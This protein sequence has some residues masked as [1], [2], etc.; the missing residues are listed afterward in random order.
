MRAGVATE[1]VTVVFTDLVGSTELMSRRGE[2]AADDLRREHFGLLRTAVAEHG[3][4]EVKNLGDGLMVVF[5]AVTG[6]LAC[7]VAMQQA[8]AGRALDT[9][10]LSIRVG[11][12]SGD[13]EFDNDDYFGLPVVEA[14]RLC[15][16]ADGGEILTTELVRMLARSRSD[17]ELVSVGALELKGLDEPV[18]TFRVRWSPI[19][20]TEE[21]PPLPS[22]L[23]SART[24]NFVGRDAE[25]I[26]LAVA[27]KTI[28]GG[29]RRMMFLAGEPGIGKTTL[30]AQFA[31]DVYDEGGL[32]VYGRSDED[33]GVPYQPWIEAFGQLVAHAPEQ[34]LVSHVGARGAH[35]ARLVPQ[36]AERLQ[37]EAP[38]GGDAD[39]E[40]FVLYGCVTDL[41]SRM[42]AEQPVLFVL[43][44]LHWA[45]R[46]TVQ[47][48][49][50][51]ANAEQ[52]MRVGVLGTFRDSEIGTDHPV[53][54]L[55]A[56]LH[57][58]GGADRIAL[59]GFGDDE[60]LALL[61][62]IAG[63]DM[64]DQ[65]VALRD[66]LLAETAGNPFFV[67]EILRH[68]AESGAIYQR[69]DGRWVA[70]ADLRAAGLPVSV[71]EVIGRRIA[72]LGPD[73]ERV[74][75][76]ASVIGRDFDI[77]LLAVVANIDEDTVIDLCD[78]AVT[79]AVLAT[80]D[81]YDRYTFAHALIEHTLYDSLSPARRAR[82]HNTIAETLETLL[83]EDPGDRTAELAYHW[84]A[85]VQP[86]DTA[87]A[88]HYA[89]L[90]GDRALEQ[91]APDEAIR[92]YSQALELLARNPRADDRQRAELLVGLGD[93]QR[94]NGVAS[95]RETLLEATRLADQ[96]DDVAL[97]VRAVFANN[98]GY[99]SATGGVDHE[100]IAAID[101]ALEAVGPTPTAAR[102]KLL[103]L[104]STERLHLVGLDERVALADGAVAVARASGD[105]AALVWALQRPLTAISHPSTLSLR[106]ARSN[107]ACMIADELVDPAMQYWAHNNAWITAFERAD[108]VA[109]D[110]HLRRGE[111]LAE[112]VPHT[113]IRHTLMYQHAWIA[114][115]HG[116]LAEYERLAEAALSFGTDNGERDAFTL[117]AVQLANIRSHEGRLHE[118]IPLI[119]Q[120]LVDTPT[121]QAYRPVLAWAHARAGHIEPARTM[122]HEDLNAGL[123]MPDDAG[124]SIGMSAW[125]EV[126]ALTRDNSA[127]RILRERLVPYRDGM[128]AT[129]MTFSPAVCHYLG[130][131]D[132]LLN[133]Y[134]DAEQWLAEAL[135]LHEQVR[136]P[137]L[138]AETQVA[139]AAM[140][141]DRAERYDHDRARTMTQAALDTAITG[142]Y[143]YIESD[144]RAVLDRLSR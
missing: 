143:G 18:E 106:S 54:E 57:R 142:G 31:S 120:A 30:S 85:A 50:Q 87:K 76:L 64:D 91:L 15:A 55:L 94:Q 81:R 104:A 29:A 107:E 17:V 127:A 14:S 3:G 114:G 6:A 75:A 59:R 40:R 38:S 51:V 130:L 47:L 108:G 65:G 27:W 113:S 105:G 88:V 68:L 62:T 73:T 116:D 133:R 11:V 112:Q 128:V 10:P 20:V 79:A 103:A 49:R 131:V 78:A 37:V 100:R 61:E 141:A 74:L 132:H 77:S 83:G 44:D 93:A 118:L 92:W 135:Q 140:L 25:R 139:W 122:I 137:K 4:R 125:A 52:P 45:D 96:T 56:A 2:A 123:P 99:Q 84:A 46:A 60:L 89:Q 69:D 5:D 16:K 1:T 58:E 117:Y 9:E 90:A 126:A 109:L 136:A 95:Y 129:G 67:A 26:Q 39:A 41:L 121:L 19:T 43:D 124:W 134:D 7:A 53:S 102:A 8:I 110:D 111:D 63:H 28:I 34:V 144:A 70:D 36:L 115:L 48:L 97:L 80:T 66:A 71:R 119:E 23:E 86:T 42:S 21:R 72:T 98:R 33:L 13:A 35:L 101:R 82:A 32:V 22:R 24:F 12:A 138:V